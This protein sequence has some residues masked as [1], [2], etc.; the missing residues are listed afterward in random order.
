[1]SRPQ[2]PNPPERRGSPHPLDEAL[3]TY[4]PERRKGW[5]EVVDKLDQRG[6]ELEKRFTRFYT[7]ALGAFAILGFCCAISLGGF[8]FILKERDQTSRAIQNQRAEFIG[9]ECR[10]TNRRHEVAVA[11]LITGAEE[12]LAKAETSAIRRD[13]RRRR[14][15][16]LALLDAVLPVQ[17]C[18]VV[19]EAAVQ[20]DD[21]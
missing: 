4:Q 1:M 16:T 20:G 19:V 6:D 5:R 10:T 21:S 9:N 8:S 18:K 14:D 13:I 2:G 15:V 3:A 12:D 7:R 11:T 17:N